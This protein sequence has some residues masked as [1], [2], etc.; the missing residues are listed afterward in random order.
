MGHLSDVED[1]LRFFEF[2][3]LRPGELRDTSRM[4]HALAHELA[5]RLPAAPQTVVAL[6]KLLESKDAAVRASLALVAD[7]ARYAVLDP[8]PAEP[9]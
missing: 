5:G 4:F 3:H 9:A 8:R 6:H 2:E 7:P 1:V